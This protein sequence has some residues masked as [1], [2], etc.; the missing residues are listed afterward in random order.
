MNK[1]SSLFK[2]VFLLVIGGMIVLAVFALLTRSGSPSAEEQVEQTVV[3]EVALRT[4]QTAVAVTPDIEATVSARLESSPVATADPNLIPVEQ[5][6]TSGGMVSLI[7][8]LLN[9]LFSIL[10]S[11]WNVFSFGGVWLQLCCCL[12]LPL[13]ALIALARESR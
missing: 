6:E 7:G 4:T 9:S 2:M 10:R 5:L 12:V 11:L 1:L 13:G 3:A 8:G